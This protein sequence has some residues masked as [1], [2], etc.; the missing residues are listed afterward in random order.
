MPADP[1]PVPHWVR[2]YGGFR[3]RRLIG[4]PVAGSIHR[5]HGAWIRH[6]EITA[7]ISAQTHEHSA[8]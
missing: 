8:A 1:A 2:R 7:I 6:G 3:Q 5:M 4:G